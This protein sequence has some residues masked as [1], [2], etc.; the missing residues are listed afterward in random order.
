VDRTDGLS[1]EF[2]RWRFN[3]RMSNTEPLL[4]LNVESREDEDLMREKTAEVLSLLDG[5][6]SIREKGGP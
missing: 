2:A 3:L 1:L 4:R 5:S 6:S